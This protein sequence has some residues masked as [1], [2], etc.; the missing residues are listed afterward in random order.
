MQLWGTTR[1]TRD[2]DIL[3]DLTEENAA[4]VL[5]A[6]SQLGFGIASERCRLDRRGVSTHAAGAGGRRAGV[7]PAIVASCTSSSASADR[8]LHR[9][10][11]DL[12]S[13]LG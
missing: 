5:S 8:E 13:R 7:P 10:A 11:L 12:V 2:I 1:A 3:I 9:D 4:R 6:R